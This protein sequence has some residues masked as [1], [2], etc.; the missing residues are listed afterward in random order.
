MIDGNEVA[1]AVQELNRRTFLQKDEVG[2]FLRTTVQQCAEK[3]LRKILSREIEAIAANDMTKL[4]WL[5]NLD[6]IDEQ[7]KLRDRL[8]RHEQ[9]LMQ[10]LTQL[11]AS[12][13][14]KSVNAIRNLRYLLGK[15]IE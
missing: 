9:I 13:K 3:Q 4:C 8:S 2:F 1:E 11:E 7:I 15:P 14:E 12:S 6:L 10:A 5:Q